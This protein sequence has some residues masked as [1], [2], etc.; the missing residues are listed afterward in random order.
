MSEITGNGD[1]PEEKTSHGNLGT[2]KDEEMLVRF[3]PLEN[4]NTVDENNNI[5]PGALQTKDFLRKNDGWS[6]LRL[7]PEA[8]QAHVDIKEELKKYSL[9]HGGRRYGYALV[10][11]SVIRQILDEAQRRAICVIDAPTASAPAH[12][13][14]KKA[15]DYSDIEA[16]KIRNKLLTKFSKVLTAAA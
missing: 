12:V 10:K 11:A 16:R 8:V 9:Q 5:Q 14:A 2:V 4:K 13:L 3:V 6:L 7:P 15:R 1:C